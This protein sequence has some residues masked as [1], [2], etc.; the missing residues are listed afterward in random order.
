MILDWT[1]L[2]A[3]FGGGIFAAA[4]GT[5]PSFIFTGLL[6]MLGVAVAMAGGGQELLSDVAFG[7]IFGPHIAFAG[8]V[9]ATAYASKQG[10]ISS[11]RDIAT[12]LMGLNRPDVLVVGGCFGIVGYLLNVF[13]Q[14]LGLT[15]WTDT[16]ALS[17]VVSAMIA[18]LLFGRSSLI[19]RQFK[20]DENVNWL[21]HQQN[22]GQL[23]TI[24]LGV[25][26]VS[27]FIALSLGIDRGGG[28][29]GFG[30]AASSLIFAQFGL[31]VPVT[32]H[33][34]L[35]AAAAALVADN[36]LFGSAFGIIGAFAGEGF[37]RIFHHHGDTHV[38]PPA[39]GIAI[40][41]VLVRLTEWLML[42]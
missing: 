5:L 19:S 9:A 32:H 26:L 37:S 33:I 14:V 24:G 8:G 3:A 42:S 35:P 30:I 28:V 25:G 34:A 16:I 12:S 17:V 21:P 22:P 1:V 23:L 39:G 27:A 38:D 4:I 18:R 36:L 10:L 40:T 13:W 20:P 31:K 29:L 41:I 6:V 2:L 11:G 15:N 7:S